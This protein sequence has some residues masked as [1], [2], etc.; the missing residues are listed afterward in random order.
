M[1][2]FLVKM[3]NNLMILDNFIDFKVIWSNLKCELNLLLV[4]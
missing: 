4:I 2:I 1:H 3:L